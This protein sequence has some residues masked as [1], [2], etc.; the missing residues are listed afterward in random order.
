MSDAF[1]W[2]AL[3]L[4]LGMSQVRFQLF[5]FGETLEP[6]MPLQVF[7]FF[8]YLGVMC[9]QLNRTA[10]LGAQLGTILGYQIMSVNAIACDSE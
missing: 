2:I 1:E 7:N 3:G 5:T 9:E 4:C 6:A 8:K 10:L